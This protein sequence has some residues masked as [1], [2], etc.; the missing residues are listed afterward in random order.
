M[1]KHNHGGSYTPLVLPVFVELG[2]EQY[3]SLYNKL[4][5]WGVG[6]KT[7]FGSNERVN[8]QPPLFL[9][10]VTGDCSNPHLHIPE[11]Y[12]HTWKHFDYR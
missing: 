7:M 1:A 3:H 12:F 10:V 2:M 9:Q 4:Q 11:D 6:S 5:Y 8:V